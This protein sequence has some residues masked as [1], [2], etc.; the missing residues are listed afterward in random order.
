M[1][2]N[3]NTIEVLGARVLTL[4]YR[5]SIPRDQLV[6]ISGFQVPENHRLLSILFDAEGQRR[7]IETFFGLCQTIS[8][9][10]RTTRCG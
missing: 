5:Y 8:W 4:K 6:V 1:L 7:Y 2:E 9:R 10:I 3:D